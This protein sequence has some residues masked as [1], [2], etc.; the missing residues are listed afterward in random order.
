MRVTVKGLKRYVDRTGRVRLYHRKSGTPIDV[1]LSGTALA[2]EVHRLDQL[3]APLPAKAGTLA[4]LLASYRASQAF[5]T[6]APRTQADYLKYMDYLRPI[7]ET[8]KTLLTTGFVAKLRDKAAAKRGGGFA[9]HLLAMLS[10]ACRHAVEYEELDSNPCPGLGKAKIP[11]DRRK[12]NRPWS[13]AERVNVLAVA[14]LHLK[15]PLALARFFGIRAGDILKLP[16]MAYRNGHLSFRTSK[17]GKVM[18]LP[19]LGGLRR[20]LDE[21]ME[22]WPVSEIDVTMLCLNSRRQPWTR[23]GF[24]TSM[25]KFFAD[26]VKRG[27]A[28]KGL[29]VHG[30]R[31]TIGAELKAAGYTREQR[32]DFLGQES[33]QMADHYASSAD[34]NPTL[35]DMASVV[36]GSPKR[37]RKLSNRSRKSV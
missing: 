18:K 30:L 17:T 26:C 13:P 33:D 11:L 37:E 6:L 12:E 8:P 31:H 35:I 1:A 27:I 16:R 19:V 20:I 25:R 28:D 9:N 15:V 10:S 36:E 23:H 29:T 34:I 22:A 3:H 32:K 4:A 2:A 7:A 5:K 14:P 21:A 24:S